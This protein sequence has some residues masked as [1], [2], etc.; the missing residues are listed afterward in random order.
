MNFL[1][2]LMDTGF[3]DEAEPDPETEVALGLVVSLP[4][5]RGEDLNIEEQ[6]YIAET[7]GNHPFVVF[8]EDSED[9]TAEVFLNAKEFMEPMGR[10]VPPTEAEAIQWSNLL[11][12][13]RLAQM[14]WEP[15]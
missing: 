1:D 6:F 13:A 14:G 8:S 2:D 4:A 11:S 12:G 9:G 7:R 15:C 3:A 10:L 5:N